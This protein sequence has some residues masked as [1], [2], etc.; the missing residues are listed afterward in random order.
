[1]LQ[2]Y[3]STRFVK[4]AGQSEIAKGLSN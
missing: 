4:S 2:I 1:M 3:K